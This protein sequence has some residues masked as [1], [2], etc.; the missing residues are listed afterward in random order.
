MT[1]PI[2]VG[3]FTS[4]AIARASLERVAVS[5]APYL[6]ALAI[7]LFVVVV[8]EDLTMWLPVAWGFVEG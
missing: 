2:G 5:M 1:P 7:L 4:A 6:V 3:Y 8:W